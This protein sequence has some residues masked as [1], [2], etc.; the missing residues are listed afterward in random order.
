MSEY[1][2][3]DQLD[4]QE[5]AQA[6][7]KAKPRKPKATK[8]S[9]PNPFVQILNGEFLAK[10]YI[11]NNLTYIFFFIFM[12]IMLVAKGYYGKQLNN[13]IN[14]SQKTLDATTAEFVEAKAKL[15]EETRRGYLV[16]QLGPMGLKETVNP[17][18]VIRIKKD[19]K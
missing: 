11:L 13:D 5:D 1:L 15:E 18:K 10:D 2:D 17:A 4:E 14:T 9:K 16:E 3:K 19:K 8:R 12:M 7:T 6:K